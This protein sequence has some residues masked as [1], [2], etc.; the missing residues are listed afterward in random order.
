MGVIH[1][2]IGLLKKLKNSSIS[3]WNQNKTYKKNHQYIQCLLSSNKPIKLELGTIKKRE[4]MRDW[5]TIDLINDADI[6]L[7]LL[8]PIPFP[9]NSVDSIYSS[10]FLEHFSYPKM[11]NLLKECNR[12]LKPGGVFSVCVPNARLYVDFYINPQK[13]DIDKYCGYKP[14]YHNISSIDFL[15]YIAYMDSLHKHMFDEDNLVAILRIAGFR[16]VRIRVFDPK[17]DLKERRHQSIYAEGI[18]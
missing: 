10:H 5:T 3:A 12:I 14:A 17:L 1:K 9:S 4:G 7:N 2:V 13:C 8:K 11:I 18:K 16:N 15:N 6:C